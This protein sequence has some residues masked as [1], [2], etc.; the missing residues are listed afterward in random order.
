MAQSNFGN[1]GRV[2][3][4]LVQLAPDGVIATGLGQERLQ[5]FHR[6]G[7][8]LQKGFFISRNAKAVSSNTLGFLRLLT[9][10]L[11]EHTR[12]GHRP[13]DWNR[14]DSGRT[15]LRQ[16]PV[17]HAG[18]HLGC[19]VSDHTREKHQNQTGG[20]ALGHEA[21]SRRDQM[22][23]NRSTRDAKAIGALITAPGAVAVVG[24]ERN[25]GMYS[26]LTAYSITA[27]R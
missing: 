16:H 6:H 9:R 13:P 20:C 17:T 27:R 1:T 5:L 2:A 25:A 11:Q 3:M 21:A 4:T 10:Q 19:A 8:N 14:H 18:L 23:R 26:A 22:L 15:L 7:R 12:L 24:I